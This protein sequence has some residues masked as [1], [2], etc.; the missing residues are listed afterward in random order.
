MTTITTKQ[1]LKGEGDIKREKSIRV[2]KQCD[3]GHPFLEWEVRKD[4]LI[5]AAECVIATV[6]G[7][8]YG[9]TETSQL[10]AIRLAVEELRKQ[11]MCEGEISRDV[12]EACNG[13]GRVTI[14]NTVTVDGRT[15]WSRSCDE[16]VNTDCPE[17]NGG[18]ADA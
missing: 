12:C 18:L 14:T 4:G 6:F 7:N 2:R 16:Q 9:L 10:E 8:A 1:S 13:T 17:C 11:L 15:K 3:D 5:E